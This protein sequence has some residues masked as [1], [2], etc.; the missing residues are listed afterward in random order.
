MQFIDHMQHH[1]LIINNY[2]SYITANVIAF[3]I[4]NAINLFIMPLHCLHLFQ[5][6]DVSVFAPLKHA[7]NKK[8]DAVNQYDLNCISCIFWVK[9]YIKTHIKIFFTENL[10]AR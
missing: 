5:F 10:K 4:Q 3:C 7:L 1:L 8:T 6:L 2:L 9:M